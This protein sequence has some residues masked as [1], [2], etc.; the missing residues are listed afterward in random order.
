MPLQNS[1]PAVPVIPAAP[2]ASGAPAAPDPTQQALEALKDDPGSLY[3]FFEHW[4]WVIA[5]SLVFIIAVVLLVRWLRR[6]PPPPPPTA[7]EVALRDLEALRGQV[8]TTPPYA[9]SVAVSDV[10]R[11]Y[12]GAQYRLQAPQQ[13]SPEFL[14]S[15][16]DSVKFGA[17]DKTLLA[18]F[19][20]KCDLIKFAR[21][22]A[23]SADSAELLHSAMAFVQGERV[24]TP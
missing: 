19:L 14:A 8:E 5:G 15:I 10:L 3:T 18:Q 24:A 13:T 16:A 21:I 7:R 4:A 6:R 20:E 9:F 11:R 17:E 22:E 12:I 1:Q 23:T 2:G